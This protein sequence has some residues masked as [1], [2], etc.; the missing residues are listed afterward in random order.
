MYEKNIFVIS[1]II[2]YNCS[3]VFKCEMFRL[4]NYYINQYGIRA[5]AVLIL[6]VC[7]MFF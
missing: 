3:F 7:I 4:Y 2:I 1:R 5:I 6:M